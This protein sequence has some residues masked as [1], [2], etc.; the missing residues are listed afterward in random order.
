[1]NEF[2]KEILARIEV[3]MATGKLSQADGNRL[4]RY[5]MQLTAEEDDG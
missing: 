4:E 2:I 3:D 5:V 1:M